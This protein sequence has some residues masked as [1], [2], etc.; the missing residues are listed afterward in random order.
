M[1]IFRDNEQFVISLNGQH[2]CLHKNRFPLQKIDKVLI[3]GEIAHLNQV[4]H[5][6]AYP[7][8]YPDVQDWHSNDHFSQDLARRSC[9][10]DVIVITAT[11]IGSSIGSFILTFLEGVQR[12]EALHFNP[13]F[14]TNEVVRNAMD[15]N[16][17]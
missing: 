9:V 16:N 10:G 5:H 7:Y 12:R 15:D 3:H 2:Y 17:K 1:L 11:P 8:P 14:Y 6:Q 4:D 13:R